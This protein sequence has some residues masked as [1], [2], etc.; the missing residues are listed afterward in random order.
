MNIY[1][2]YVLPPLINCACGNARL[3]GHRAALI[4]RAH[5]QVLEIGIGSALNLQ[6]YDA[7]RVDS[8]TGIDPSAELLAIARKRAPN[9]AFPLHLIPA[10]AQ[11]LPLANASIDTIVVTFSL[12]TIPDTG[13]ALAEMRRVLRPGGHLLFCEHGLA[14]DESVQRWQRRLDP[15]WGKLAGG[16]HLS[17]DIPRLLENAGFGCTD[18]QSGYLRRAP[19]FV[20]YI[21]RGS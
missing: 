1:N 3:T 21:Y 6:H 7:E 13:A 4:P 12:C 10:D 19:R 5:G 18:L 9:A 17:R 16:C 15:F 2:R 14:P 8:L 20:G 11:S